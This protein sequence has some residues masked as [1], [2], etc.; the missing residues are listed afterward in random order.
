MDR[1]INLQDKILEE[2]NRPWASASDNNQVGRDK[3]CY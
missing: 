1:I 2:T 3:G